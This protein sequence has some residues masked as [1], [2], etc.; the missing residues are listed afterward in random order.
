[1]SIDPPASPRNVAQCQDFASGSKDIKGETLR[2]GSSYHKKTTAHA[3][4]VQTTPE[5]ERARTVVVVDRTPDPITTSYAH[6]IHTVGG[7]I[8][9]PNL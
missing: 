8:R 9:A 5:G 6:L 2:M 4:V 7:V 3:Q 1:M